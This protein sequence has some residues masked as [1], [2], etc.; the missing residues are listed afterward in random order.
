MK[1]KVKFAGEV[2]RYKHILNKGRRPGSPLTAEETMNNESI[3]QILMETWGHFPTLREFRI[4]LIESAINNAGGIQCVAATL[5]G[6]EKQTLNK[7]FKS[8]NMRHLITIKQG[9]L[10]PDQSCNYKFCQ[11]IFADAKIFADVKI[12]AD[13]PAGAN[14]KHWVLTHPVTQTN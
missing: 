4:Y 12:F 2:V 9:S 8:L 13:L 11:K 7:I 14:N 3:N 1:G 10:M 6:L 5:L